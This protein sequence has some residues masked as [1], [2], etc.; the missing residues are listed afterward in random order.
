MFLLNKAVNMTN[1]TKFSEP[2][3]YRWAHAE[4]LGVRA[5]GRAALGG[6]SAKGAILWRWAPSLLRRRINR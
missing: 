3:Y 1:K 4:H 6:H 2:G 5:A